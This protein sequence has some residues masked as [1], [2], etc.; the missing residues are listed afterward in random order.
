MNEKYPHLFS[1]LKIGKVLFRNRIFA[2]PTGFRLSTQDSLIPT[3]AIY[4]YGRKAMGGAAAV[5]TGE[6]IVDGDFGRGSPTHI[7]PER[8]ESWIALG[9][10]A[11]EIASYGAAPVAELQHAGMYANRDLALFGGASRG[12][13][14]GPV[15]IEADGRVIHEMSEEMILGIAEKYANAARIL[16]AR[17]FAMIL[18]HAGHGWLLH[19]FLSPHL[20]TRKDKWGGGDPRNR[21]RF[22][23]TVCDA[24][25]AA[26]G[27]DF[28]IEIRISGS[29]VFEGGYDIEEGI[30]IA[31]QLDGHADIL[32]VSCGHHENLDVFSVTHPSM[33]LGDAC[34]VQ[35]AAEIK[36]HVRA[37]VAAVGA[38]GEPEMMEE[39][40][41]SGRADVVELARSLIADPD[42]PVKAE[43]GREDEIVWCQRC[44]YCFS[45]QMRLGVKYC[46][47][48]PESGREHEAKYAVRQAK[49]KK[50]VL[51]AGGGI[52]G[53]QAALSAVA[54]GHET[55]L[56]EKTDVLGGAIL[57]EE[58]VPFKRKLG[59][60]IESQRRAVRESTIELRLNT[61]VTPHYAASVGA[62]AIIAAVGADPIVPHIAGIDAPHVLGAE[63]AYRSPDRV[64]QKVVILGAG[65][66]GLELALYLAMTG[67]DLVVV[68]AAEAIADGG[69]MLHAQ[70][71][72]LQL[73][74]CGVSVMPGLRVT[75]I[76][77]GGVSC[78]KGRDA[79]FV[80]AD[81]T[82]YAVGRKPLWDAAYDLR[83]AAPLLRIVGDA[84]TP[85]N[86]AAAV[87][88]AHCAAINLGRI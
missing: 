40:L 44:L 11:H 67:R 70:A 51:I 83:F 15:E 28:P 84:H 25:R 66:V 50:R 73:K 52:G 54:L 7:C 47:V 5:S 17:G 43:S 77:D 81:T 29:E 63:E 26:V 38:I 16:K 30:E 24:V 78:E 53:M 27:N 59:M 61:E 1:P 6:L 79:L 31:K 4:Y 72:M 22:A 58:H 62:D 86:M 32:H 46:A 41:A 88:T 12:E 21:A 60:Y 33:F 19:Q 56:C 8:S 3:E 34:N 74:R 71:L 23:V 35:Y 85:G 68:E 45:T 80:D 64:G 37:K 69:N 39:I 75:A 87:E 48:N 10:L 14:Y 18:I 20:N 82:I 9:R 55:I 76:A 65:L 57:C 49:R 42:L 36:K 13:A 2:A